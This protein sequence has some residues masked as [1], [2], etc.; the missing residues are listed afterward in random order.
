MAMMELKVAVATLFSRF[1]F[2]LAA[3]T[4]GPDGVRDSEI[5]ALTLHTRDGIKIHC[6]PRRA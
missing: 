3:E 2:E 6:R 1:K 5:M 4:G